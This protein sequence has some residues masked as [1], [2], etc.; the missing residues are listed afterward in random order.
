MRGREGGYRPERC[1]APQDGDTPLH[2]AVEHGLAVV[3]Q[4]LA[5]GAAVDAKGNVRGDGV[6]IGVGW[7]AERSSAS[8]LVFLVLCFSKFEFK[9][10]SRI[11]KGVGHVTMV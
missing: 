2:L 7:G 5:A 6:W 1:R 9:L 10:A 8:P 4:L 11:G 3:E